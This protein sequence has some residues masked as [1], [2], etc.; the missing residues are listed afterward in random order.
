ML[1]K[2]LGGGGTPLGIGVQPA[3]LASTHSRVAETLRAACN[4]ETAELPTAQA[5]HET[6]ARRGGQVPNSHRRHAPGQQQRL[7]SA[8]GRAKAGQQRVQHG[9]EGKQAPHA[10]QPHLRGSQL[11]QRRRHPGRH[12]RH[13]QLLQPGQ[14]PH[15]QRQLRRNGRHVARPAAGGGVQRRL[16]PRRLQRT[17][18]QVAGLDGVQLGPGGGGGQRGVAAL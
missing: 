16:A 2:V 4:R 7:R 6:H 1:L 10:G 18:P 17:L 5:P 3:A 11:L 13:L 8:R 14:C 12:E 9:R 15:Q